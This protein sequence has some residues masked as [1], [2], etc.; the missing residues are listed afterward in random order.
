MED[1]YSLQ[2]LLV[3]P[4]EQVVVMLAPQ[5]AQDRLLSPAEAEVPV[6]PEQL[7]GALALEVEVLEPPT[8]DTLEVQDNLRQRL[9]VVMVAQVYLHL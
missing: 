2:F 4:A 3:L 6:R 5:A 1:S 7:V 9:L 8:K